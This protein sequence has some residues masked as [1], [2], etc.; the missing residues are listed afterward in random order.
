LIALLAES[1][2]KDAFMTSGA[3]YKKFHRRIICPEIMSFK[4]EFKEE[5][6]V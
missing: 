1:S 2:K 6:K 5:K 3:E 4:N